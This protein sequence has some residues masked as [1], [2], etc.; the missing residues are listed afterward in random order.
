[1]PYHFT[2]KEAIEAAPP[3]LSEYQY[4]LHTVVLE[5]QDAEEIRQR[6]IEVDRVLKEINPSLSL[7]MGDGVYE[8]TP[9]QKWKGLRE[10]TNALRDVL[11]KTFG[12][13]MAKTDLAV[14]IVNKEYQSLKKC[15]IYC[16]GRDHLDRTSALMKTY[17]RTMY[18][19][20]SNVDPEERRT[21]RAEFGKPYDG[22]P[23]FIGAIK[24]LDEGLDLPAL[25]SAILVSSNRTEREWIQRRGRILRRSEGKQDAIIHDVLMLPPP[26]R[27]L[28]KAEIDFIE[29][30]LSRVE[31]FGRDATNV[32]EV[33]SELGR[34]RSNYG[35]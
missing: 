18:P 16:N 29:S 33:L 5:P 22:R 24:C 20:D 25:D 15:I 2:L 32:S 12:R 6:L 31:S 35:L 28:T 11:S 3:L 19:Y 21:I 9:Q 26:S 27:Y 1:V 10:K 7:S 14:E 13:A 34:L 8:L 17:D 4:L 30:E 23:I